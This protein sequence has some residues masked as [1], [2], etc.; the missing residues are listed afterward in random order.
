MKRMMRGV[1]SCGT[2]MRD[3]KTGTICDSHIFATGVRLVKRQ[4][5]QISGQV[6]CS[7]AVQ[8]PVAGILGLSCD[9]VSA[10]LP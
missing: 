10:R 1:E 7:S 3:R 4:V 2:R 5:A 9:H 6:M 8:D